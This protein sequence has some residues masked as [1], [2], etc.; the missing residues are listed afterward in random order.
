M[1]AVARR[2]RARVRRRTRVQA[3]ACAAS[4]TA[5]PAAADGPPRRR[6]PAS[7]T[8]RRARRARGDCR[9]R[10]CRACAAPRPRSRARHAWT[11][12]GCG[13]PPAPTAA[14]HSRG[15]DAACS[16]RS[17]SARMPLRSAR[18]GARPRRRRPAAYGEPGAR[19]RRSGS[20]EVRAAA[21]PPH[22]A[23]ARPSPRT[24][25]RSAI[26]ARVAGRRAP[27]PA[28]REPWLGPG[29]ARTRRGPWRHTAKA[30]DRAPVPGGSPPDR[31]GRRCRH[32]PPR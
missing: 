2:R 22:R 14:R 5:S 25:P 21:R 32:G 1:R 30:P 3:T 6:R 18:R 4:Q 19:G 31:H 29:R 11:R 28:P 10:P 24:R 26:P 15:A 20:R 7:R 9:V 17:A 23:P 16:R 12:R 8:P 13:R 27:R